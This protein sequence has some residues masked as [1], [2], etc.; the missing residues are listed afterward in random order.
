MNDY[1]SY[2]HIIIISFTPTAVVTEVCYPS[3]LKQPLR[4][5]VFY[6]ERQILYHQPK[7]YPLSLLHLLQMK[8]V[9]ASPQIK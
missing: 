1:I 8:Q 5:V 9:L 4:S 2:T 3:F 7:S 6:E